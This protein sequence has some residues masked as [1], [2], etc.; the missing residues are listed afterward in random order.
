MTWGV[1][2]RLK[3]TATD[4]TNLTPVDVADEQALIVAADALKTAAEDLRLQIVP[5][6]TSE[7]TRR[8]DNV[9]WGLGP[10]Y[11]EMRT[12][13]AFAKALM[14]IADAVRSRDGLYAASTH[15]REMVNGI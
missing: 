14:L 12:L 8:L 13:D 11:R 9:S 5:G 7:G 15:V 3:R 6:E 10:C 2:E 4:L 1:P